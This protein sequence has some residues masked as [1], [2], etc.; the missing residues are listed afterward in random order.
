MASS[1]FKVKNGIEVTEVL[2]VSDATSLRN[3]GVLGPV[4]PDVAG[5]T[6]HG[7]ISATG[8]IFVNGSA[9]GGSSS[10]SFASGAGGSFNELQYNNSGLLDGAGGL[11]YNESLQ[12]LGI[13][14]AANE[15]LTVAG[16]ISATG[17]II[18]NGNIT[19]DN[20]IFVDGEAISSGILTDLKSTSGVY[21]ITQDNSADWSYVAD[22]SA[23]L[24]SNTSID[25]KLT[26][27]SDEVATDNE[28]TVV[29]NISASGTIFSAGS[30]LAATKFNSAEL[31]ASSGNW[32]STY[33]QVQDETTDLNV[34][35]GLLFI[36]KSEEKIGIGTSS[37]DYKLDV[38]G[39]IGV[40]SILTTMVMMIQK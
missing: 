19:V 3:L 40:D 28:L 39:N 18:T 33:N 32:N 17:N 30:A 13:G 21:S 20:F 24:T 23:S 36:D 9:I 22:N 6:V 34:L 37:P 35:S 4:D 38:A 2:Y 8:T 7:D 11:N 25:G 15:K 1:N 26:V 10:S 16:N 27:N 5:I 31:A 14:V 29:G 12:G